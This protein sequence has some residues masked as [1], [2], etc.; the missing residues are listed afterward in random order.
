M[1]LIP[2]F[3]AFFQAGASVLDKLLLGGR[4]IT[5]KNFSIVSFLAALVVAAIAFLVFQ[6][7]LTGEL[8]LGLPGAFALFTTSTIL[9]SNLFY[10]SALK[11]EFLTEL[12]TLDLVSYVPIVLF[13]FTIFPDERNVYALVLA[14]IASFAVIWSH[15][16]GHHFLMKRQVRYYLWWILLVAP[17]EASAFKEAFRTWDPIALQFIREL[18]IVPILALLYYQSLKRISTRSFFSIFFAG[19][20]TTIGSIL[21]YISYQKLGVVYTTLIF[22]LQPLLIY[23]VSLLFL[24]EPLHRKKF[25]AFL[26]VLASIVVAQLIK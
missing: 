9:I 11:K 5:Y 6:P 12:Q 16:D 24:K 13:S 1:N 15:W 26:I 25:V 19:A 2:I 23:I 14:L 8:F 3:G 4:G 17:L 22:T 10:Y 18:V 7:P 21:L 20:L